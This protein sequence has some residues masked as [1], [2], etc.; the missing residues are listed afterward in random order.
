MFDNDTG[1]GG[2]GLWI[3][4]LLVLI[5]LPG[6]GGGLFGGAAPVINVSVVTAAGCTATL[7]TARLVKLA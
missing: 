2:G 5:A 1:F 7:T 6:G 3:F 4:G